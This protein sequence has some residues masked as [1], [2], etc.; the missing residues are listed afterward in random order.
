M[1]QNVSQDHRRDTSRVHFRIIR[2]GYK[3]ATSKK[4][5]SATTLLTLNLCH[6]TMTYLSPIL[7][8]TVVIFSS[9]C[10]IY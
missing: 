8:G 6:V 7:P 9:A 3:G 10:T 1:V 4:K 2:K 5:N